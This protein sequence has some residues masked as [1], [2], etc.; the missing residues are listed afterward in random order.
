MSKTYMLA[1]RWLSS[2]IK[3]ERIDV[4]LDGM[5]DWFRYNGFTWFV[6]TDQ[7][8]QQISQAVRVMLGSNDSI[9]VIRA[10][11]GDVAGWAPRDVWNWLQSKTSQ[12]VLADVL[13]R[14]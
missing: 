7:S 2:E 11:P 1:V 3:P 14:R 4:A 9:V 5:G 13:G 6:H 10:D 12:S 8:A